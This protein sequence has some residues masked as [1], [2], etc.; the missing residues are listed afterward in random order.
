[1]IH[2]GLLLRSRFA[3]IDSTGMSAMGRQFEELAAV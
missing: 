1:M 2:K 3:G